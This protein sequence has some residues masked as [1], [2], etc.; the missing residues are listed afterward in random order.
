MLNPEE[1]SKIF[2]RLG[3]KTPVISIVPGD[4]FYGDSCS[5]SMLVAAAQTALQ[6][7]CDINVECE[8]DDG[9]IETADVTL[10]REGYRLV[11]ANSAPSRSCADSLEAMFRPA[12]IL[13]GDHFF[14][15]DRR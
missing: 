6:R 5:R 15:L 10:R 7:F 13:L 9:K 14:I 8:G 11:I 1:L 3:F 2:G 12:I 4:V